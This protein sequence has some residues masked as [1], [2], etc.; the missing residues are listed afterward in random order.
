LNS[1]VNLEHK[2]FTKRGSEKL[3]PK[4]QASSCA[5]GFIPLREIFEN[6]T[7]FI[8][9]ADTRAVAREQGWLHLNTRNEQ[10]VFLF[11]AVQEKASKTLSVTE[12]SKI[13]LVSKSQVFYALQQ[14]QKPPKSPG[15]E[16]LFT[17]QQE[18]EI[19]QYIEECFSAQ[20]PV[21]PID[22]LHWVNIT[23]E[24][25]ATTGWLHEFLHRHQDRICERNG[26]SQEDDRMQIPREFLDRYIGF[27]HD[28]VEGKVAD[29]VF[30]LD[31]CGA[32]DFED[33]KAFKTIVPSNVGNSTILYPIQR[34]WRHSTLLACISASG[35]VLPPLLL[36]PPANDA[37]I[38][39]LGW[40]ENEDF[41]L[42]H[43][44]KC[45]VTKEIFF[46]YVSS[47]FIPYVCSIRSK[48]CY[49]NETAVLLMDNASVHLDPNLIHLLS[50]NNVLVLTFPP[51]TSH[52]FQPCDLNLFACFKA[53]KSLIKPEKPRSSKIGQILVL[54]EAFEKAA[55]SRNIRASFRKAG[56]K[57]T[58]DGNNRS[59]IIDETT[60]RTGTAFSLIY[61]FDL[62]I[63]DISIRRQNTQFG[64][65]NS[66]ALEL[67]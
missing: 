22:L 16:H 36:T 54:I 32:S 62:Q 1:D 27:L 3:N 47:I 50:Q 41:I 42:R 12:L 21:R 56:I 45:Y 61:Q 30:N 6:L 52:L 33:K 25:S 10:I 17:A 51:H 65:L 24:K 53:E 28:Y 44:S 9:K 11:T 63:E 18:I 46:D 34:K 13:F 26:D 20:I 35:D 57:T 4:K 64:P 66:Q 14:I 43:A 8:S 2:N 55:V 60:L 40:R 59:C 39:E 48:P 29:L 7:T 23:F 15:R 31:E 5:A 49:S 58:G 67:N 37:E 38:W 19:I